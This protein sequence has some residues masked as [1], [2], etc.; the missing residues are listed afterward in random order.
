LS[1][2]AHYIDER[3]SITRDPSFPN[4]LFGTRT[5]IAPSYTLYNA[6]ASYTFPS[7]A[8]EV[9]IT[10]FNILNTDAYDCPRLYSEAAGYYGGERLSRSIM[11]YLK[12]EF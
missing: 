9:G 10:A 4:L 6:S 5:V 7:P 8:I 1:F 2:Q 11:V 3:S 12:G